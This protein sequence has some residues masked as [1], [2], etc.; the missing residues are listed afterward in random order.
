MD[1]N[2]DRCP[3]LRSQGLAVGNQCGKAPVAREVD[4]CRWPCSGVRG[5]C[6]ADVLLTGLDSIPG[7]IPGAEEMVY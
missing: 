2:C 4:G 7:L 6:G 1:S 5:M 3:Q